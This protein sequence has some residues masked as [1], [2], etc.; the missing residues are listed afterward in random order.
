MPASQTRTDGQASILEDLMI[1]ENLFKVEQT[2]PQN[3]R[4]RPKYFMPVPG[5][6]PVGVV[7]LSP[8]WFEL[9]HEVDIGSPAMC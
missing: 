1:L 7:N 8:A 3:W 4:S 5:G 9:G 6:L 2:Q